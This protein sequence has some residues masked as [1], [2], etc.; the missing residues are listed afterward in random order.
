MG[1]NNVRKTNNV[2]SNQKNST[3]FLIFR[4][5]I[6]IAFLFVVACTAVFLIEMNNENKSYFSAH[7]A[8]PISLFLVGVIA[9]L[10][11]YFSKMSL[12][13][14]SKGDNMMF[15]VGLLLMLCSIVTL[16]LSYI[17]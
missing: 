9:I 1:K 10:L 11:R 17:G 15:G 8:L 2:S 4:I 5:V 6:V 16:I 3:L 7:F 13:G 12:S 14:E